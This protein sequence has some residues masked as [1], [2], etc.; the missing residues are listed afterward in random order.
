MAQDRGAVDQ[1][2]RLDDVETKPEVVFKCLHMII[3]LVAIDSDRVIEHLVVNRGY[4][5]EV[6]LFGAEHLL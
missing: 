3:V 5:V 1:L 4:T 2:L 6:T